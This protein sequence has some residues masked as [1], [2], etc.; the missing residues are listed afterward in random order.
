[1]HREIL[2]LDKGD[3]SIVDHING[4]GWDNRKSNLRIVTSKQNSENARAQSR[5]SVYKGVYLPT[6]KWRASIRV[7]GKKIALGTFNSEEQAALAYDEA[8]RK[9]FDCPTL[10]FPKEGERSA[11]L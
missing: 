1:M 2:N 10:N 8:A 9:Y 4:E 7:G 5:T 11:L 3:N 6:P